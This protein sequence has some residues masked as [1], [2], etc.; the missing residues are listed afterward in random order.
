MRGDGRDANGKL[1]WHLVSGHAL[2]VSPLSDFDR[3]AP[4]LSLWHDYDPAVKADLYST[5]LLTSGGVYLIDP[6]PLK[7]EA[8]DELL[9]SARVTGIIVTNGNHLRAAAQFAKQFSVPIFARRETFA[10][11]T[12]RQFRELAEGDK[13]CD[14]LYV[15]GIEGAA[16][17]EIILHCTLDHGTLFVGDALINFEPYGFT[18]LP[19]KYCSDAKLMRR[20]LR[21]LLRFDFER[22]LFAHGAPILSRAKRKLEQLLDQV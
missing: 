12:T 22:I 2:A 15:I 8:F 17:G 21:Q 14:E 19:S 20:S 9:G 11:K 13:I 4:H 7:S 6:I 18:F 1:V 10:D 5:C 16:T 3:I